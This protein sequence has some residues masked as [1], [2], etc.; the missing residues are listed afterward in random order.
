[1]KGLY[2]AVILFFPFLAYSQEDKMN[3]DM[4][5]QSEASYVMKPHQV[6]VEEK[7]WLNYFEQNKNAWISSTM[8]RVG[9]IKKLEARIMIEEGISRDVFI[10]ETAQSCSPLAL[11]AK[12]QLINTHTLFP[13]I[14]LVGYLQI[15]LT[16]QSSERQLLWAPTF[17]VAAEKKIKKWN[18]SVNGGIKE[19]NFDPHTAWIAVSSVRYQLAKKIQVFGE[20]FAQYAETAHPSHNADAGV[21]YDVKSRLQLFATTGTNI[22][23]EEWNPFV[24]TGFAFK[25]F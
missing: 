10:E 7:L 13:N 23:A 20:Y 1:M 18:F 22:D 16:S 4:P 9:V 15:P 5:D 19:N 2:V 25:L 21:Q 14:T 12:Y 3:T 17:I 8:I 6:Q 11:S 24:A